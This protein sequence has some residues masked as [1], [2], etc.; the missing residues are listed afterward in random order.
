MDVRH[1]K[2][3]MAAMLAL[4]SVSALAA[5]ELASFDQVRQQYKDTHD[6]TRVSYLYRRCAALQLNVAALLLRKKQAK[7]SLDY[8]NL[9]KHYMLLAESVD[10]EVDQKRGV[11]P[12]KTMD[13]INLSV[14]YISEQYDQRMKTNHAKRGEY[15]S[16]DAMLE[17]ELAECLKPDVFSK[18]LQK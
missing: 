12:S 2:Y 17:G 13:T 18:R 6:L 8:E 10:I 7:A 15:F 1:S 4:M 11:K 16:G 5:E 14:K 3:V 9:A